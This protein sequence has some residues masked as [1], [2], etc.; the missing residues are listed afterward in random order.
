MYTNW[1][2]VAE[3]DLVECLNIGPRMWG[4]E[5][6]GREA[7]LRVWKEW[8]RSHS[9]NSI[10]AET[11]DR[12][13]ANRKVAFGG[14]VFI[15]AEF[16][17]EELRN[18]RPGLTSRIVA[19]VVWGKSV[20]LPEAALCASGAHNGLDVGILAGDSL[21]EGMD[22]EEAIEAEM[23][24]PIT[25]V[26]AHVGYRLNRILQE[27]V[28]SRQ[29][30][31]LESSGVWRMV[32]E[33]PDCDGALFML[34]EKGA[35]STSGSVVAPLFRYREPVL[36]L[37][38]TDKQLLAEAINGETDS[39]LAA[40]LNLSLASIKKRWAGVF[41][42]IAEVRPDLLPDG[43]GRGWHESRGPQKRH[44]ILAYVRAHPEELRPFR[45]RYYS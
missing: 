22:S 30:K 39:E 8:V 27:A 11:G 4:D 25:F 3:A 6:V 33:F 14:S 42:R 10:V 37:R 19:S 41:D 43:D 23:S 29:C 24:L 40:R 34:T 44:R 31:I 5:I 26:G 9:F 45:W 17:T 12:H 36:H 18:P 32:K 38:D 35:R 2:G 28:C 7:A 20:V 16:A 15:T 13:S 21:H 1:R